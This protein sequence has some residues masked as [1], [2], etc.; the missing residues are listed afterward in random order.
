MKRKLKVGVVGATGM[1]G[2]TFMNILSERSFP[3]E[4]L[5]PFAS[6]N[7]LGK[8]IELQGQQWPCQVLKDGCF[9]GLDLV[10]FSS[11]DDISAE[12]APKAVAAGAFAVD[13]S[14]AFRMDPNTVLIVPEVNGDLVNKDSKPQIIANPNCSTIQL[15]VAL[16][17][18][19]E[20]FGLEEVRVSTYQAVSG[21][22]QGGHDELIEQTSNHPKPTD[23]KT[24]P[25]TIL[26]NCIPQIGSFNDEG[27]SSE[28]VKIMKE[29][30]KILGQKDLKV[31]AFAVRIP[32]LNAH[33]ESVWVTLNKSVSRDEVLAALSGQEGIVVQDEPKKS[34]YP[35][36]RD[37]SGKDPVYVGRVHRDPENPK[38]WLMWVVSD[39]IRKGAALNGIQIA[40]KIFFS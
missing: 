32:A 20:K 28:E 11:G 4:E 21:A 33:S 31:S 35:L 30:R 23:P 9:D 17:P 13:N 5:R 3:I 19:L 36:A 12:W 38:M 16:K 6:E 26:F 40:E 10:F 37:V 39:N 2:Q 7:S 8:K 25:H 29:T 14:A 15:V 24:F 1:V 34:V 22:G 27:Y 18:L